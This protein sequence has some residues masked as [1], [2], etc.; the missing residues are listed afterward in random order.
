MIV[1]MA[2]LEHSLPL[3]MGSRTR[4]LALSQFRGRGIE[5]GYYTY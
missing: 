3:G 4:E 1:R 2:G 5:A